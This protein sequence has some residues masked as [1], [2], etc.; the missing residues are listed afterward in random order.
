MLLLSSHGM[1]ELKILCWDPKK[2]LRTGTS[3]FCLFVAITSR[4][5]IGVECRTSIRDSLSTSRIRGKVFVHII[6]S[7]HMWDALGMLF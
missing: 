1:L 7:Y 5:H 2:I 4:F 6:L 3:V